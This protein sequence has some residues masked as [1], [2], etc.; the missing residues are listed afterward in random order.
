[1]VG[2]TLEIDMEVLPGTLRRKL[3]PSV[4]LALQHTY[5]QKSRPR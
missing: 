4:G 1:V 3:D 2:A 5:E